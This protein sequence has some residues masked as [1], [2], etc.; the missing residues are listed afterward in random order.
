VFCPFFV[1]IR[2][3]DCGRD[4]LGTKVGQKVDILAP[5][6]G[7]WVVLVVKFGERGEGWGLVR[8]MGDGY[9]HVCIEFWARD[10]GEIFG[11]A[12]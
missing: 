5:F 3:C 10:F 12:G 8:K 1:G 11:G 4:I 7:S 6:L 9:A 2:G